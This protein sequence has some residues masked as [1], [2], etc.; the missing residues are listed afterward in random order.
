M[1]KVLISIDDYHPANEILA[2]IFMH[3]GLQKNVIFFIECNEPEKVDQIHSLSNRG[4]EIGSHTINHPMDI[5]QLD[6]DQLEYEI[7]QSRKALQA[8]TD[9]KIEW[10]CYPRGR[11]NEDVVRIIKESGYLYARTTKIGMPDYRNPY[12]LRTTAHFFQRKEYEGKHWTSV[13]QEAMTQTNLHFWGHA[14]EIIQQKDFE[15]IKNLCEFLSRM[16]Q[17]KH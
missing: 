13:A 2:D 12:E 15:N 1:K 14:K 3:Y 9:Q 17:N 6:Y 11:Y 5:K 16:I 7:T 4:F 8:I 10:F